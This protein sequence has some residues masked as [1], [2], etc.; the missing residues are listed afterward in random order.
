MKLIKLSAA[1]ALLLSLGAAGFVQEA[2][3]EEAEGTKTYS[4]KGTVTL[5]V[6]DSGENPVDP[7]D[8]EVIIKPEKPGTSGPLSIDMATDFTFELG[9]VS[10]KDEIY[11][12]NAAILENTDGDKLDRP[13]YV[14]VTDKRGGQKGW[15]LSLTQ[16]GQFETEDKAVLEGAQ[17]KIKNIETIPMSDTL[18]TAP[19]FAPETVELDASGASTKPILAAKKDE[20]GGTWVARFGDLDTMSESVEL[21]IP[22]KS[23][24]EA[25]TYKT[26]LTWSL[27]D[28]PN[29][30]AE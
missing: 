20:G 19:S 17:I 2:N 8:P 1:T 25:D 4:T 13:N 28:V 12:A 6:D 22:G 26:D 27:S 7:T 15:T 11:K 16:N 10:T 9:K 24:Q 30:D 5:E 21:H 18:A 14:Q 3:A 23:V 29:N